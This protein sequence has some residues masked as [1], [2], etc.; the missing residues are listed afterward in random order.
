MPSFLAIWPGKLSNMSA[1]IRENTTPEEYEKLAF[2]INNPKFK[3][4]VFRIGYKLVVTDN[5]VGMVRLAYA[6]NP[7]KQEKEIYAV[8]MDSKYRIQPV[9]AAFIYDTP[10]QVKA[11]AKEYYE[12][13][14]MRL[15]NKWASI[16]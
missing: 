8:I 15:K 1:Q 13:E 2:F 5:S 16:L 7:D 14:L 10:E 12:S 3:G 11:K 6:A 9:M 4:F